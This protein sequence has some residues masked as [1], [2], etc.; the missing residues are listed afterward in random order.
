VLAAPELGVINADLGPDG[1]I[2][3]VSLVYTLTWLWGSCGRD[4]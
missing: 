4:Q 3:R 1:N 2:T